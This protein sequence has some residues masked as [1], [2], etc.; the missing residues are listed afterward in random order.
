MATLQGRSLIAALSVAA[1]NSQSVVDEAELT[2]MSV[3]CLGGVFTAHTRPRTLFLFAWR[4]VAFLMAATPVCWCCTG[5]ENSLLDVSSTWLLDPPPCFWCRPAAFLAAVDAG[6]LPVF[7][8]R[9]LSL[10]SLLSPVSRMSSRMWGLGTD[11]S[12]PQTADAC[13][14]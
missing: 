9:S 11:V 14:Q 2:V 5:R 4:L 6:L 7:A 1:C 12:D 13:L 10:P 3:S 8:V